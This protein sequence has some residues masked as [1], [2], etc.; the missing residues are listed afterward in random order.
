MGKHSGDFITKRILQKYKVYQVI[1]QRIETWVGYLV[2]KVVTL[3]V[4]KNVEFLDMM[5]GYW[6]P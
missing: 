1:S 3:W 6:L 2:N 4:N 5:R